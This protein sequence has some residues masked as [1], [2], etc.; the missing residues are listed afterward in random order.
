MED[1]SNLLKKIDQLLEKPAADESNESNKTDDR[2]LQNLRRYFG[3]Q[4]FRKGQLEII[5]AILSGK[6]V[7]AALPTGYGKSICY[8]L[9]ALMLEGVIIVIS[10]LISLMKD[11]LDKLHMR[12]IK[13]AE[14]LNSSLSFEEQQRVIRR[15]INGELKLLYVSPERLRSRR[16]IGFLSQLQIPLFVVDEAH[17]ISE[18][19]HDFRPDYLALKDSIK[20]VNARAIALFTATATQG[21]RNDILNQLKI[22]NC[23]DFSRS[24]MRE[25]L[26][27]SVFPVK[28]EEEKFAILYRLV[29]AMK[30][31]MKG[32]G[33]IYTG[34][35]REAE[36]VSEFLQYKGLKS[37]FYHAGR[38]DIERRL[39]QESFFIDE[40]GIEIVC[41]T[42]AF[43]LG[44]DKENIRFVIH[45]SI[46]SSIEEYYQQA[47]RAGRDAL[48]SYCILL[49]SNS[50]RNLQEWFIKESIPTK[51]DLL[52]LLKLIE[53]FPQA[54]EFRFI[55]LDELIWLGGFSELKIRVGISYLE[56]LGFLKRY[57]NIP[58]NTVVNLRKNY[59]PT[60]E[61]TTMTL[62]WFRSSPRFKTSDFCRVHNLNP[63]ELMDAIIDLQFEGALNYY[64]KEEQMLV[65]MLQ[66]PYLLESIS[67]V[68]IG[69]D[70][71]RLNRRRKLDQ[72]ILY[73]LTDDCRNKLVRA[74]FRE[75]IDETYKCNCCDNCDAI[76]KPP[77]A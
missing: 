7:L 13:N 39:V 24:V 4:D 55:G 68:Q 49:Y 69:F 38:S 60:D 32:K 23:L 34:K 16:L 63:N 59:T 15:L 54:G 50:D 40:D 2:A 9:P 27:F 26:K 11:Q 65:Q 18:W 72:M 31:N 30:G 67:E 73:A 57:P 45:W 48:K 76:N 6:N 5:E 43:G 37:D 58:S 33:I 21:V 44:I 64:V 10:P 12:G 20:A 8:Q 53:T 77:L 1:I 70:E 36:Q 71:L 28:D 17:C 14:I 75:E 62:N 56:K 41:A 51:A 74:Y 25:N 3:H 66:E 47:G 29:S 46:P 61:Q 19:G 52:K 42:N 22:E 35:R